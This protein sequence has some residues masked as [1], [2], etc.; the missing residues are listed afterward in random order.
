MESVLHAPDKAKSLLLLRAEDG[1]V[2]G[3]AFDIQDSAPIRIVVDD[4]HQRSD[5]IALNALFYAHSLDALGVAAG[6]LRDDLED[7]TNESPPV[8]DVAYKTLFKGGESDGWTEIS[9]LE[10][11]FSTFRF[12]YTDAVSRC[13][14]RQG[15]LL[16]AADPLSCSVPCPA[17]SE[18]ADFER[19]TPPRLVPCPVGWR[20]T[21]LS[22]SSD[23][24]ESTESTVTV[25]DPWASGALDVCADN[26]L[27]LP[28]IPTCTR[29][30]SPCDATGFPVDLPTGVPVVYVSSKGP[31]DA[32]GSRSRPYQTLTAALESAGAQGTTTT[33][34]AVGAGRYVESFV[35]HQDI[36]IQGACP[37]DTLLTLST[38]DDALWIEDGAHV[39]LRDLTLVSSAIVVSGEDTVATVDQV[40]VRNAPTAG[41][42]A[43][44]RARLEAARVLVEDPIGAGVWV[45]SNAIAALH[46]TSVNRARGAGLV[47]HN[48]RLEVTRTLVRDTSSQS[49]N[50]AWPF[51]VGIQASTSTVVIEASAIVG[52]PDAG[53]EASAFSTV[54]VSNS[55][56]QEARGVD[57]PDPRGDGIRLVQGSYGRV[58]RSSALGVKDG[59]VLLEGARGVFEDVVVNALVS[60]PEHGWLTF[61]AN[62]SAQR[63][64][65][66]DARDNGFIMQGRTVATLEDVTVFGPSACDSGEDCSSLSLANDAQLAGQRLVVH[67]NAG[68]A[69]YF[70]GNAELN[71]IHVT[72]DL[73]LSTTGV[74]SDEAIRL[75]AGAR[76]Q[77][78][79]ALIE[80][81]S[82]AAIRLSQGFAELEDVTIAAAAAAIS[83]GV[84]S[85]VKV[86]RFRF[87][88]LT[89][90][91]VEA[92]D[93]NDTT[94]SLLDG[95]I[96]RTPIGVLLP[97]RALTPRMFTRVR[98]VD[99]DAYF[100]YP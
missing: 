38:P 14:E 92:V 85:A 28:G 95:E 30:G 99:V 5:R 71:D 11:P 43:R 89:M 6:R 19:A 23:P 88:D 13:A 18:I 60:E 73:D 90:F 54:T 47:A 62:L 41:L 75:R 16:D 24:S 98:F 7:R 26:A 83:L 42:V 87:D 82:H 35:L 4:H 94:S 49:P 10:P 9:V 76:V 77:M 80:R 63:V 57:A 53:I 69:A 15:C 25:C 74:G 55:V 64:Y 72:G 50:D 8:F 34:L 46:D 93:S 17:P 84:D 61:D 66:A 51:G 100:S 91:A 59:F 32:D 39:T 58:A 52:S 67:A 97:D 48:A 33:V 96:V 22:A 86:E 79:R 20:S 2:L 31:S 27:L 12:A 37:D 78:T 45:D 36:V 65:V 68:R 40:I 81:C 56:I 1:L 70:A 44:A 21:E 29:V 3:D